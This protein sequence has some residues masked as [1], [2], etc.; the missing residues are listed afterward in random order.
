M[1]FRSLT[2]TT[3][4]V[5]IIIAAVAAI[6]GV[7]DALSNSI[8][9]WQKKLEDSNAKAQEQ[10]QTNEN[11]LE[12]L[13]SID[14]EY[15]KNIAQADNAATSSQNLLDRIIELQAGIQ[16]GT[17]A[18]EDQAAAQR[19]ISQVTTQLNSDVENL[20]LKYDETTNSLNMSTDAVEKAIDKQKEYQQAIA[21]ME[22]A[23]RLAEM[24]QDAVRRIR[25]WC[26]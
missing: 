24:Q 3:G 7:V 14:T 15:E 21:G 5:G 1:L 23:V 13:R 19:E 17:I 12:S 16:N 9:G 11:L 26:L 25:F 22:Q 8:D 2:T 20:G 10:I 4:I 18:T 6:I